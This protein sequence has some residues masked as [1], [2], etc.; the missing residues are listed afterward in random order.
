[1]DT[2][3]VDYSTLSPEDK[4]IWVKAEIERQRAKRTA[5]KNGLSAELTAAFDAL[6]MRLS[7]ENLNCDGE[8]SR[9]EAKRKEREIMR[10]WQELEKKAGR[11]VSFDE[12]P[13]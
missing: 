9:T 8:I 1:M 6:S 12:F 13:F 2:L 7:P 3:K 10:E 5:P 11:K 4:K